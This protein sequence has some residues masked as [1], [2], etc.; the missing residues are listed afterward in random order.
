LNSFTFPESTW[1]PAVPEHV[2]QI[3]LKYENYIP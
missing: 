3:N 2:G 1:R